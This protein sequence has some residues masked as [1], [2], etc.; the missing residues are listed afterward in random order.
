[1]PHPSQTVKF[2]P[3]A[4][5]LSKPGG[6]I[7]YYRHVSAYDL[8]EAQVALTAELRGVAGGG[9]SFELRKVREIGPRYLE[10]VADI[11]LA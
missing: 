2:L 9:V 10:L 6:W 8:A 1:M 11:H 4:L 3:A 7:H 5:S